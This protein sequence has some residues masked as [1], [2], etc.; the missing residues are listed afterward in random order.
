LTA[1][2][3]RYVALTVDEIRDVPKDLLRDLYSDCATASV[4]GLDVSGDRRL[5]VYDGAD[6]LDFVP[7][8]ERVNPR[9]AR[10]IAGGHLHDD[11]ELRVSR[12]V[13]EQ[14]IVSCHR[15]HDDVVEQPSWLMSA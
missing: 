14:E 11:R 3:P 5:V 12:I 8:H 9:A 6:S 1:A 10:V 4:L 7:R 15:A 13:A 2:C